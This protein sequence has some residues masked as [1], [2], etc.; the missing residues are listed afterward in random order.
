MNGVFFVVAVRVFVSLCHDSEN[1]ATVEGVTAA[2]VGEEVGSS[3]SM[4]FFILL[5]SRV[6]WYCARYLPSGNRQTK[7]LHLSPS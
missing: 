1:M 6:E 5:R 2:A 4:M 7:V 3:F